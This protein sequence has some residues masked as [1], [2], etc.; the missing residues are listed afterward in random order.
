MIPVEAR[1]ARIY[2]NTEEHWQGQR[3]YEAIVARARA[4][5]IAG[6]SV[7]PIEVGY[8]EGRQVHDVSSDYGFF[9]LP[10]VIEIVD[11]PD[12]IRILLE[13]L[14]EMISH[15]MVTVESAGLIR[16]PHD[17]RVTP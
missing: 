7:F 5:G 12:R 13:G 4:D 14:G 15:A 2:V 17:P 8:G 6:A 16:D 11:L 1:L 10:V 9:D 3:L